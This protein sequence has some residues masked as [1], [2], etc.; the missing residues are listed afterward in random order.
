[1]PFGLKPTDKAELQVQWFAGDGWDAGCLL[2][3]EQPRRWI[4]ITVLRAESSR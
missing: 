1:M 4:P 3:G 2:S